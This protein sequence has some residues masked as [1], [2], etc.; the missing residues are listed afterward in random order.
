MIEEID[1]N[2]NMETPYKTFTPFLWVGGLALGFVVLVASRHNV[3]STDPIIAPATEANAA[4]STPLPSQQPAVTHDAYA[5]TV[6]S[7]MK[8]Y[9]ASGDA[10]TAQNALLA[11]RVPSEDRDTHKNLVTLLGKAAA[12]NGAEADALYISL[13]STVTW[14]P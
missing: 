6:I 14:L 9:Q 10:L 4:S 5:T 7:I 11:M 12:G 3:S 2:F 8:A 13:K 1:P